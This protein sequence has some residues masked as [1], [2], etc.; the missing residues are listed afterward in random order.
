MSTMK[1]LFSKYALAVALV[2]LV[3]GWS[4]ASAA[5]D[6]FT[7]DL[8]KRG[9]VVTGGGTGFDKG[10]WYHYPH[11]GQ[12]V[13]W[14]Y[15]GDPDPNSKKIVDVELTAQRLDLSA[16]K[17]GVI[18]AS[19]NWTRAT[20]PR[21]ELAPPL[22]DPNN[23]G[24]AFQFI[25]ETVFIPRTSVT[26]PVTVKATVE[27]P[28][29]CPQWISI[30]IR[31]ENIRVEGRVGHECVPKIIQ[32]PPMEDRDFGDAPEGAVAYPPRKIRGQFPT[33]VEVGPAAWI[34]HAGMGKIYF[35]RKVDRERDGNAGDCPV[36]TP[37]AYDGD[38]GM[39]DNDAGIITPR[40]YTIRGPVGYEDIYP[41]IF[42]GLQSMSNACYTA[43]WGV[44]IDIQVHN[45]TWDDA[46]VNLLMD[47]NHDGQWGR[48]AP[49]RRSLV[50]EHA[51]VNFPVPAGYHGPLSELAP[52]NFRMGPLPG[53]V[54]A[55]FTI[56][57]RPVLLGWTGDGVFDD[58]E[59]EDYLFHVKDRP[60]VC[61]WGWRDGYK[62]HWPQLPDKDETGVD[63]DLYGSSLADDF[64]CTQSGEIAG[65]HFWGS[66]KDDVTPVLGVDS[67]T[68]EVNIYADQ[69]ADSLIPWSRP[70][71]LLW[72]GQIARF[73]YDVTEVSRDVEEDWYEPVGDVYEPDNHM[74]V[75]QYDI[76]LDP[77]DELFFQTYDE[78]Y[79][80]E[81]KEIRGSDNT[82]FFGWKTTKQDLRFNDAAV[83]HHSLLGWLPIA[84]PTGHAY[85]GERLDLAFVITRAPWGFAD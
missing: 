4:L 41:L 83:W 51:L 13:Q 2:T 75:Y 44:D 39:N 70:G 72:T 18:E 74:R 85:D 71:A 63:V 19:V 60:P 30:D 26:K 42:T 59:T 47:W 11:T 10:T 40:A 29:L 35:G 15:N 23:P 7:L 66:F 50:P 84:Y 57:E 73:S 79:W 25:Q 43:I 69:P 80:L 9:K 21:D 36:F 81:V 6:Q 55:R 48:A 76:C 49:C 37:D 17:V 68:F 31:G 65:I 1:Q 54:W 3:A 82:Y 22:P 62:M 33:C 61:S 14:F 45:N 56:S 20:W 32:M 53:Y 77:N 46:Y 38:E 12:L 34:E 27:I 67:L 5:E 8:G 28:A 52:P 24:L 16:G 78:V 58:G 64:Q